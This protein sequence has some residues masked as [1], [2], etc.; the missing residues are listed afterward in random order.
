MCNR[1][2]EIQTDR[3]PLRKMN[4]HLAQLCGK[5]YDVSHTSALLQKNRAG[6]INTIVRPFRIF[7]SRVNYPGLFD[8]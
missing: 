3:K 5:T 1:E 7:S 8:P 4:D 6:T 2:T